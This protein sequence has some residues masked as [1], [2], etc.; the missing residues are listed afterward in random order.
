MLWLGVAG[1]LLIG[2]NVG[3]TVENEENA[4]VEYYENG[5]FVAGNTS[6]NVFEANNSETT[7]HSVNVPFSDRVE[8]IANKTDG[9]LVPI[10]DTVEHSSEAATGRMVNNTLNM[11][12][13]FVAAVGDPTAQIAYNNRNR[14][15][16]DVLEPILVLVIHSPW[17]LLLLK[18]VHTWQ[19]ARKQTQR[20]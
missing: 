17:L 5:T 7:N 13:A 19:R 9:G 3:Y 8:A 4:T 6:E 1:G 12:F 2:L 20:A 10:P 14:V 11:G 18:K 16:V 15:D